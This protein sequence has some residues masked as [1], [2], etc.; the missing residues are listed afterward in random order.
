[1]RTKASLL[2]I[3]YHYTSDNAL[4]FLITSDAKDTQIGKQ[5]IIY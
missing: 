3:Y 4:F 2:V 5:H 1:M